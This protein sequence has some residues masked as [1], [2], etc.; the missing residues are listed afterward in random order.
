MTAQDVGMLVSGT[1]AMSVKEGGRW[2]G[3]ADMLV[4]RLPRHYYNSRHQLF[5]NQPSG[6][7][8]NF[9]SFASQVYSMLALYEYGE[10]FGADWAIQLANEASRRVISLQGPL[11]EWAWF[12]Y[13]PGGQIVDFYEVYSV[14]QH[15]MAPAFLHHAVNHGVV[16]AREALKRGFNWLFSHNQMNIS[17]LRPM[18]NMFYRSQV[19]RGE[20][21]TSWPRGLRS[22]INATLGRSDAVTHQHG[23]VLR[24]ECRSYELGWILWSFGGRTDYTDLT[25]RSEF[26]L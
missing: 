25:E 13:I 2:R 26:S 19:R 20:L 11:G 12:Y 24:E 22:L 23:L 15:G 3:F 10:A 5:Y 16:G 21:K 4:A 17:M 6:F 9:S 18:E 8:R 7:R 14:H 1:T